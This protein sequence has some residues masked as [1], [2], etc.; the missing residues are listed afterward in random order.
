MI[1]EDFENIPLRGK[2]DA[3]ELH[4][5]AIGRQTSSTINTPTEVDH[6]QFAASST[7]MSAAKTEA[8][9]NVGSE[10][11]PH[12]CRHPAAT[13][14]A[15]HRARRGRSMNESFTRFGFGLCSPSRSSI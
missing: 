8:L 11:E 12:R 6:Y 3:S 5:A 7:S 4:A 14:H 15:H 1:M 10:I 9:S 13:Q 2:P